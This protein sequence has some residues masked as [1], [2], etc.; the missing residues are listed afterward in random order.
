VSGDGAAI[1]P[2]EMVPLPPVGRRFGAPRRVRWGDTDV[3]GRLRLDATARFLQ[4]VANDDTRDAGHDPFAPWIVRRTALAVAR[5]P[6]LGEMVTVTTFSAGHGSRWGER[7]TIVEGDDGGRV[8]AAA[9]WVYVD[10]VTGAPKRLT[11]EFHATYDE[12]AGG[13]KVAARLRLP[14]PSSDGAGPAGGVTARPWPVRRTDLDSL[15]HVNNAA[16]WV[17]FQDELDRRGLVASYAE[18]EYGDAIAPDDEVTLLVEATDPD[19]GADGSTVLAA[20]LTVDGAVRAAAH[21]RA[22][23][24]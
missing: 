9:L 22:R 4:D 15:G 14:G 2:L 20:W 17:P 23:P 5:W 10:A 11:D 7:R 18:V 21:L 3:A 12:A 6:R 19:P 16:T 1:A 8:D 24:G 13:R